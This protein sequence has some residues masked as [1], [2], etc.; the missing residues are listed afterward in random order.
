MM[1]QK[2]YD[3]DPLP[4]TLGQEKYMEGVREQL[5]VNN[6]VDK[7]VNIKEVV[8]FAGF[9][10]RKYMVDLS[11]RG[12]YMNYLPASKFSIDVDSASVLANGTVKEYYKNRI[13][14]PMVWEYQGEDVFK[15]DLAIMDMLG[16]NKWNRPVY[17]STTVPSDQYKGLEKYFVQE[18]L[19]YRVVPIKIDQTEKG[20]F[21]MID[22]DVM[23]DNLMNKFTW[24][25]AAD[26]QVYLDENNRRMFSNFKRIFASLGKDLILRGDTAKAI[27]VARR[28]LEIVPVQKMP[29]D[30]FTIGLAEVLIRAGEREEGEKLLK[31]VLDYAKT[32]LEYA[33]S[34]SPG[35]RFGLDYPMGISMQALLDIYNMSTTLKL[36]S[37]TAIVEPDINNYYSRLYSAK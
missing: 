18:G 27:E 8:Q 36:D 9:D 37:I 16:T 7:P 12:D 13:Q 32:Y 4:L 22:P 30:F 26:P 33:I 21:G 35:E 23:Y 2:A 25:N 31:E 29:N 17:F 20:E 19:A 24:G 3:S 5:P 10:D 15:G 28:G 34:L 11:G 6:R 14:S 1:R